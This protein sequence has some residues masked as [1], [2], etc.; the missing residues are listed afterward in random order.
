MKSHFPNTIYTALNGL[1]DIEIINHL[2]FRYENELI[3]LGSYHRGKLSRLI[4]P[5]IVETLMQEIQTP[6]FIDNN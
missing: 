6:L 4:R 5:S 1:P 3:V 2:K